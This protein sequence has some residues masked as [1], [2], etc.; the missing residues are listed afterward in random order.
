ME[1]I[2]AKNFARDKID[3][4]FE[5]G[6]NVT[7]WQIVSSFLKALYWESHIFSVTNPEIRNAF[8]SLFRLLFI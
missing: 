7:K 5:R 6:K 3:K 8:L 1:W 2:N 4:N